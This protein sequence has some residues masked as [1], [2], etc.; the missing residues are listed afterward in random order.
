MDQKY[1]QCRQEY[2]NGM[3]PFTPIRKSQALIEYLFPELTP[4]P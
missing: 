1:K 2:L 3:E 4:L